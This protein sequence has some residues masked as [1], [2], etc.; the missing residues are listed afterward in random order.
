MRRTLRAALLSF[1]AAPSLLAQATE[2]PEAPPPADAP[3]P[4]R[5]GGSRA[6]ASTPVTELRADM[7]RDLAWRGLG[8]A[9]PM[10]R[11]TDIEVGRSNP[12]RWFV[13][14]AGGGVFRTDNAGTTWRALTEHLP[15]ASIGDVAV[16][17]SDGSIVWIGTGEENARNSVQWG[18]GVYKS[19]DGGD[20][21]V[22]MGLRDSFQIGHIAIHPQNPDIVFVAALGRLWGPN[23]A[24]GVFR[25]RDGGHTWDRVLYLDDRTGCIDV[26]VDPQ[27]PEFVYAC[28]Y[29]RRRDEFDGNDPAVR[30]GP[31]S[32]LW[33]SSDG[34]D[35]WRRLDT[36]LPSC[37]WGRSGIDVWQ[38]QPE[39]LLLIVETERSGWAQGDRK[40]RRPGDPIPAE[41]TERRRQGQGRFQGAVMGIGREGDDGADATPGAVLTQ[42]TDDGPAAKAGLRVGDRITRIGDTDVATFAALIEFVAAA[43]P[44]QTATVQYVRGAAAAAWATATVELTFTGRSGQGGANS[45]PYGGGILF[46]QL[47]NRQDVQGP[48]GHETGG[49]FRSDDRGETWRR[50][51]SLD[52]RPFYYS[53]IRADANDVQHLYAVG[54]S[55]WASHDG[56]TTFTGIQQDIHVDFHAF[57][58]DPDDGQ[59]LLAGCDG[60]VNESFDRGATWQ[61]H[62]GFCAAQYY[63]AVADNSVPYNVVGGLQDNG[64]WVGP[65]RTRNRE[66]ITASDWVTIY[67]GDGFGA[68]TDPVE[69][70][71]VFATSLGGALGLVDLRSG[72]QVR[73][74]RE[75]PPNGQAKFN[76]DAPFALSPH[77][78]LILWSAGNYLYRSDRYAH[79]DNR[80]T[81]AEQRPIR[82]DNG[83]HAQIVSPPLGRTDAGTAVSL[84]ES[85]RVRGLVYV[86]TDDGALWRGAVG[87]RN[88]DAWQQLQ[89]NLPAMPGPR[90]VSDLVASH[91]ADNR[92]YAT[93]D[94]HRSDDLRTYVFVSDD[95]GATWTS[96]ATGLPSYEPCHAIAEDPRNENLLFLGTEYG[97]YVSLDRGDHWQPLGRDLPTVAVRDLFVQDR[98]GDLI[99]ATHGRGV[100]VL[101]LAPLRQ[102]DGTVAASAAHLFQPEDAILWRMQRR[103]RQGDRDFRAPNPAYGLDLYVWFAAAPGPAPKV[104]IFDIT[105]R[106]V[107][108]LPTSSRAGLQTL[109]WDARI[110]RQLAKPGTYCASL[111]VGDREQK[112]AFALHPDPQ[113]AGDDADADSASRAIPGSERNGDER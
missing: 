67:G 30:F 54:T 91:H 113:N 28:M 88:G 96:L 7:V 6:H 31:G 60:G 97:C 110:E 26:R 9:N 84:C 78:R 76:W 70:W 95:R 16:A 59:H 77:N 68:Q 104:L 8:P 48:L 82:N 65:S 32:G 41:E 40:E 71:I 50:L 27:H 15:S 107:A 72:N 62:A 5:A 80:A 35:N 58:V 33:K 20:T 92:I 89:Q 93:L 64:T 109:H 102:F 51:N 23:E 105:G 13:A 24:R 79:L 37:T 45:G 69:P 43:Q 10:G 85:P 46:G 18:D 49:V 73:I 1:A 55:L 87:D 56:G 36:G 57:W 4:E 63:H 34:G 112:R 66:G 103:G 106:Q 83:M 94:G 29:E 100:Q 111:T 21:F 44:G 86:G 101:D 12:Y 99:A 3:R 98:D 38:Q 90:Y 25:T 47:A 2:T 108:A 74:D 19:T 14:T 17:P 42:V 61:V 75:R 39:T 53:V 11:I 22:A 81:D 52:E